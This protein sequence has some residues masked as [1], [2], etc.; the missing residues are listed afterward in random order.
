[1]NTWTNTCSPIEGGEMNLSRFQLIV[2][3]HT[4]ANKAYLDSHCRS[5]LTLGV[6]L[7]YAPGYN[8]MHNAHLRRNSPPAFMWIDGRWVPQP[9]GKPRCMENLEQYPLKRCT[10]EVVAIPVQPS[11]ILALPWLCDEEKHCRVYH[12]AWPPTA[13]LGLRVPRTFETSWV[14]SITIHMGGRTKHT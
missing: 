12:S 11:L 4:G 8:I 6:I 7:R 1:M 2:L 10:Q 9:N 5:G 3:V 14:H 13:P